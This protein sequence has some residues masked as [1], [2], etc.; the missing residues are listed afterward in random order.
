MWRDCWVVDGVWRDCWVVDGGL[1]EHFHDG[2]VWQ[3][4]AESAP[5]PVQCLA[6]WLVVFLSSE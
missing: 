2:K 6:V 1:R 3:G 5:E 4:K